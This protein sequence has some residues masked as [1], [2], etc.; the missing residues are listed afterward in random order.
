MVIT[1]KKV[2]GENGS[3]E[4]DCRKNK[5]IKFP[6]NVSYIYNDNDKGNKARVRKRNLTH[7]KIK[8]KL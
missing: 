2:L 3:G 4:G 8:Y 6:I 5:C 7:Q 1:I